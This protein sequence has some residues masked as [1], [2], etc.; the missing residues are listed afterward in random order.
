MTMCYMV[1]LSTLYTY[2]LEIKD[3]FLDKSR[4]NQCLIAYLC[5]WMQVI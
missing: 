4:L 5:D 3:F 1:Y 2:I